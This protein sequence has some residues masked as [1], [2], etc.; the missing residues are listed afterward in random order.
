MKNNKIF[1][2]ISLT[3]IGLIVVILF[4]FCDNNFSAHDILVE[5]HGLIF[6]LF[7]F[8]ILITIYDSIKSKRDRI[9]RYR[10]ELKDYYGWESDE[11]KYR[12]RGILNRLVQLKAR[13]IDLSGCS[14]KN[15]PYTKNMQNWIFTNTRLFNSMFIHCNMSNSN[16]YLSEHHESSFL[17]ADLTECDFGIAIL[18]EC[19]FSE[20]N[21]G[22]TEFD[23]AYIN[24]SN[25]IE[26]LQ[27][28][29]N[30]GCEK[31]IEKYRLSSTTI[32]INSKEYYQILRKKNSSTIA[33]DRD[34]MIRDNILNFKPIINFGL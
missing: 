33:R 1:V 5:F 12:T 22:N 28:Q 23:Y 13:E 31:I 24:N 19:T 11:A 2:F 34:T 18:D 17:K 32:E 30:I 16:F 29:K 20:C 15:C 3:I 25:W 7:V 6:D 14:V 8:G 4:D 9:T 27:E 21:I 10:E 26:T